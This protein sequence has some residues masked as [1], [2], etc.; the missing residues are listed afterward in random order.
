MNESFSN[1][2]VIRSN[3]YVIIIDETELLEDRNEVK[4][5]MIKGT[6]MSSI[7]DTAQSL[8][9]RA[10]MLKEARQP[11][12]KP[13]YGQPMRQGPVDIRDGDGDGRIND[14][15]PQ[16]RAA[17]AVQQPQVQQAASTPQ[18]QP[19]SKEAKEPKVSMRRVAKVIEDAK[20][21]DWT[22][23]EFDIQKASGEYGSLNED[24]D[25]DETL[26]Y[27]RDNDSRAEDQMEESLSESASESAQ[28]AWDDQRDNEVPDLVQSEVDE[29]ANYSNRDMNDVFKGI[30][31]GDEAA[32]AVIDEW[33]KNSNASGEEAFDEVQSKLED[34]GIEITDKFN[35]S[36]EYAMDEIQTSHDEMLQHAEDQARESF[37]DNYI[38][39]YENYEERSNW[40]QDYWNSNIRGNLEQP[41]DLSDVPRDTW[42]NGDSGKTLVFDTDNGWYEIN[43]ANNPNGYNVTFNDSNQ[44]FG[45]TGDAGAA[46]AL[47]VMDKVSAAMLSF[48]NNMEEP[49]LVSF[50]AAT[51]ARQNVYER[52]V[53][54]V[55]TIKKDQ[56]AFSVTKPSYGDT[57]Y[58]IVAPRGEKDDAIEKIKKQ[59]KEDAAVS[60][61]VKNVKSQ[62]TTDIRIRRLRQPSYAE[63]AKWLTDP[64][65]W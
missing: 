51:E 43:V 3:G 45:R 65:V 62:R 23:D 47:R 56:V 2:E 58:F 46:T 20:K 34:A 40:L 37:I 28:Y 42:F 30:Y 27:I 36:K 61:I 48:M 16:E 9:K 52:M 1:N 55:A 50:S 17:T 15:T 18:A 33:Y 49:G 54:T 29:N 24:F 12:Q 22:D 14:G 53:R 63:I 8:F 13:P 6:Q 26:Q 64:S 19:E 7:H 35:S 44:S 11:A 32:I 57:K 60:Q 4:H 10:M 41:N 59:F 25:E 39:D 5:D 38:S 21:I 31:E